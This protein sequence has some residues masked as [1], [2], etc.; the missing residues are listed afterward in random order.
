MTNASGAHKA[1]RRPATV[2]IIIY[3]LPPR[4]VRQCSTI[5]LPA[6]CYI[7]SLYKVYN[8]MLQSALSV[9]F[10]DF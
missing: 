1:A 3:A 10:V 5:T 4:S 2:R 6:L 9:L 7:V 8:V